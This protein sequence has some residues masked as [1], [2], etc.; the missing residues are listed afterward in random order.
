MSDKTAEIKP[1]GVVRYM[2]G[3]I[4]VLVVVLVLVLVLEI[5][6]T[7][8]ASRTTTS[9]N[10]MTNKISVPQPIFSPKKFL[11]RLNWPFFRPAAGLN[12][13]PRTLH[14][15]FSLS[16]FSFY[17]SPLNYF[18]I[19]IGFNPVFFSLFRVLPAEAL[20]LYSPTLTRYQIPLP[21]TLP[22]AR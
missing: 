17:L 11:F 9:T 3:V 8:T 13:E 15:S 7:K 5:K 16:P 14:L 22:I 19:T 10:R 21:G 12:P 18:S 4:I 1:R 2:Q 20:L 6:G